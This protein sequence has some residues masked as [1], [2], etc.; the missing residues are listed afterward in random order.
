[1]PSSI[2]PPEISHPAYL[3]NGD[4]LSKFYCTIGFRTLINGGV[5]HLKAQKKKP[6]FGGDTHVTLN[7]KPILETRKQCKESPYFGTGFRK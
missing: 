3:S 7:P 5:G 1:M 2:R 6:N 4:R